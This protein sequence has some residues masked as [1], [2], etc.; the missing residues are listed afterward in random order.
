[1]IPPKYFHRFFIVPQ[2][3]CSQKLRE[4]ENKHLTSFNSFFLQHYSFQTRTLIQYSVSDQLQKWYKYLPNTTRVTGRLPTDGRTV[5]PFRSTVHTAIHW[6]PHC[7]TTMNQAG[8]FQAIKKA[9]RKN[10]WCHFCALFYI[11]VFLFGFF[12]FSLWQNVP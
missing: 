2:Q 4:K 1:M 3:K 8:F 11:T 12:F 7:T 10:L 9:P 6:Q 5:A